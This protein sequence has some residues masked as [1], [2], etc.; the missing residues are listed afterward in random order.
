MHKKKETRKPRVTRTVMNRTKSQ[1][2]RYSFACLLNFGG[3]MNTHTF[4][5]QFNFSALKLDKQE[6]VC[7]SFHR[8]P[9]M[10][11]GAFSFEV[12]MR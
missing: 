5:A 8:S 6:R 3:F 12:I 1:V 7:F 10:A 4:I 11:E 9:I 2:S